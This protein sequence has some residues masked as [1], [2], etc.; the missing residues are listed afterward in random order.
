MKQRN[1]NEEA[2]KKRRSD[3]IFS[4]WFCTALMLLSGLGLFALRTYYNVTGFW[5]AILLIFTLTELG[6]IIPVWILLKKRLEEI[7]G[8]EEDAAT[9]Y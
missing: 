6:G 1:I 9:Q 8:G 3:A 5:G 2:Q 4:A 7:E